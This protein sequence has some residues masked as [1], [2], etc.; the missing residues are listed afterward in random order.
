MTSP[1][2]CHVSSESIR[3]QARG[4][5]DNLLPKR[6]RIWICVSGTRGKRPTT[7]SFSSWDGASSAHWT[8][9]EGSHAVQVGSSHGPWRVMNE[10]RSRQSDSSRVV[11]TTVRSYLKYD[12][13]TLYAPPLKLSGGS[14]ADW[15]SN[16]YLRRN[17]RGRKGILA[18]Y[19]FQMGL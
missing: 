13:D 9:A 19:R 1:G 10:N 12:F 3:C 14:A 5:D 7:F 11:R 8:L 17:R 6:P 18:W 15:Y 2:D 4:T 16:K